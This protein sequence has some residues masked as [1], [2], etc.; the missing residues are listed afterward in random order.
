MPTS[1]AALKA[2]F[3]TGDKPTQTHFEELIDGSLNL[4]DGGTVTGTTKLKGNTGLTAGDGFDD[5]T[6]Y[7]SWISN[8]GLVTTTNILIDL[9]GI[10]STAADNII[11]NDGEDNAH[12]GQYTIAKMGTL[13]AV[14]ISCIEAPAGGDPDINLA[15]ANEGTLAENSALS[16][17]GADGTLLNNGDLAAEKEYWA[18][19]GFPANNQYFYLVAGDDTDADYTAGVIH[20]RLYGAT[21]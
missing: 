21:A 4:N 20:I 16:A 9:T 5:A 7:K 6:L 18:V 8:E 12:I 3:N 19:T 15:F 10:R 1:A 11:G 2:Y 13:F 14:H 17:G